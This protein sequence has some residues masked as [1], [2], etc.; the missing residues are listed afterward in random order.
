MII[1]YIV[2]GNRRGSFVSFNSDLSTARISN[3]S[4]NVMINPTLH[5]EECKLSINATFLE[6][7]IIHN[8]THISTNHEYVVA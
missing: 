4:Q 7:I 5:F 3:T 2:E 1:S 8:H 6:G